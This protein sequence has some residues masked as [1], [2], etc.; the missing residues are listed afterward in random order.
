MKF[1][2]TEIPTITI[3]KNTLLF[4]A[5]KH[6]ESDFVG[7]DVGKL[8]IPPNYNVFFYYTPFAVDSVW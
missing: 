1:E 2:G 3:P 6:L 8:C 7:V 4:R 5:S